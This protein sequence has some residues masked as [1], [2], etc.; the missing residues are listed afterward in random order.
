MRD[1]QIQKTGMNDID[2]IERLYGESIDWLNENGI[3]QWNKDVYPTK[4]LKPVELQIIIYR[5]EY[6][7]QVAEIAKKLN[8][9]VSTVSERLGRI[10]C[11]LVKELK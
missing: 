1:I 2:N 7:M 8:K 10:L 9:G 4:A 6:K 5:F 11:K 3:H